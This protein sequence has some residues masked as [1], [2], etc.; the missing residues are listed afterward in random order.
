MMTMTMDKSKKKCDDDE[1]DDMC[2]Y[3]IVR[4]VSRHNNMVNTETCLSKGFVCKLLFQ[5]ADKV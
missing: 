3:N 1:D 4:S 2:R 5:T